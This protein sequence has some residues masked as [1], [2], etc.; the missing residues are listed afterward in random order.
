MAFSV[1]L[2]ST[3]RPVFRSTIA[4]ASLI[5]APRI[6][7]PPVPKVA[8]KI[9]GCEMEC[10][11]PDEPEFAATIGS[12]PGKS[13][14]IAAPSDRPLATVQCNNRL[15]RQKGEHEIGEALVVMSVPKEQVRNPLHDDGVDIIR[16]MP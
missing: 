10:S 1:P 15:K 6:T 4:S 13:T 2:A 8:L 9:R 11:F 12:F 16:H 3:S 14:A 5:S 7:S